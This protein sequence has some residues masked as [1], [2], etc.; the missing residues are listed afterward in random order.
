MCFTVLSVVNRKNG[1][2][3]LTNI[4]KYRKGI[5]SADHLLSFNSKPTFVFRKALSSNHV[6]VVVLGNYSL[7]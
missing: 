4:K 1:R 3:N 7:I 6:K 2:D 5:G